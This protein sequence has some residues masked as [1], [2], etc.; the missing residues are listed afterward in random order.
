MEGGAGS[1]D[2]TVRDYSQ[3]IVQFS[4]NVTG[5]DPKWQVTVPGHGVQFA[6]VAAAV[7]SWRHR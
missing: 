6:D 4:Y 1:H 3:R 7:H 5:L 2:Y